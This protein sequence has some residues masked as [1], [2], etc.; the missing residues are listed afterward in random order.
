MGRTLKLKTFKS[1]ISEEVRTN[2]LEKD[3]ITGLNS[4]FYS[5]TPKDGGEH[6]AEMKSMFQKVNE[7]LADYELIM[8][9]DDFK[10]YRPNVI[11]NKG[12]ADVMIAF[13]Y[14]KNEL[15]EY[16]A[17]NNAK[18]DVQWNEIDKEFALKSVSVK[19]KQ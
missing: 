10:E 3:V 5:I 16:D 15:G 11:K 12:Q 19:A 1:F 4:K 13:T 14:T 7:I 9:G 2:I 18:L 6:Y 17:I 8:I